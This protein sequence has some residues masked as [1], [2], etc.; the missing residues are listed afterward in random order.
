MAPNYTLTLI[1]FEREYKKKNIFMFNFETLGYTSLYEVFC[2]LGHLV[3]IKEITNSSNDAQYSVS[4]I[5][6]RDV[7]SGNGKARLILNSICA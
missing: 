5:N 3:E 7:D 2:S 4:L 1:Q 6:V